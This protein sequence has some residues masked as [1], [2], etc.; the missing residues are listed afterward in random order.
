MGHP[1]LKR[2]T[3]F[4]RMNAG[5]ST[6]RQWSVVGCQKEGRIPL[7]PNDAWVAH[8]ANC[9]S[10]PPRRSWHDTLIEGTSLRR[11]AI[12]RNSTQTKRRLG[13]APGELQ[14]PP[15]RARDDTL[16]EGTSLRRKAIV[17][18]STQTKRWLGWR[19]RRTADPSPAA[20]G[21]G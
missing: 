19:T 14:I 18:N 8:P 13:G 17:R 11:K 7:K 1:A 21:S 16:I 10:L 6:Q 12:V 4:P 5:A 20:A 9:R 15:R 2:S 3:L